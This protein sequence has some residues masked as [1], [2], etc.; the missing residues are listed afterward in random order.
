[1]GAHPTANNQLTSI[2]QVLYNYLIINC[3]SARCRT[4]PGPHGAQVNII[5]ISLRAKT[6]RRQTV[7]PVFFRLQPGRS[8]PETVLRFA[9]GGKN[10]K[11]RNR[12][13]HFLLHLV[14]GRGSS[15]AGGS[16]SHLGQVC[17]GELQP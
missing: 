14:N 6:N 12:S 11:K 13:L 5:K 8:G 1:V 10:E 17:H 4:A 3:D 2:H 7:F 9:Q 16:L 15:C